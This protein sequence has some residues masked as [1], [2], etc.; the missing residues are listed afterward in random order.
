MHPYARH[1]GKDRHFSIVID[2]HASF[3][4]FLRAAWQL[5]PLVPPSAV[6]AKCCYFYAVLISLFSV[7]Y[8]H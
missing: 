7:D 1:K 5:L 2:A 3:A 4:Y 8:S 6:F